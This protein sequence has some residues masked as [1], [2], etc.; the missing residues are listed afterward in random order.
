M[1]VRA[2]LTAIPAA[3]LVSCSPS[4][5]AGRNETLSSALARVEEQ[6]GVAPDTLTLGADNYVKLQPAVGEKYERIDCVLRELNKPEFAN[7]IKLGFVG[8]EA[9]A[10][11]E[12][13]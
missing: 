7:R 5:D 4:Q 6:C 8:N 11:E 12:K 3:A 9:F 1:I 13:E 10:S 2:I